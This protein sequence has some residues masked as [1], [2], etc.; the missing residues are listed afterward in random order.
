MLDKEGEESGES[1]AY[2]LAQA[3]LSRLNCPAIG[4]YPTTNGNHTATKSRKEKSPL[5][6]A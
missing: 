6:F 4:S 2:R 3:P 5:R 1:V